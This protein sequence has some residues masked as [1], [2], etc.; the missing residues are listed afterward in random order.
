MASHS[1]EKDL[2]RPDAEKNFI[3]TDEDRLSQMEEKKLTS[4]I[5]LCPSVCICGN[6]VFF[7]S[8]RLGVSAVQKSS[9]PNKK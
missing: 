2:N 4:C 9:R 5:D 7:S 8:L 3:A 1:A 6:Q